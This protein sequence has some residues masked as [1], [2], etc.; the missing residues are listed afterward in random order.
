MWA[1]RSLDSFIQDV[2]HARRTMRK[3]P[4]FVGTAILMLALAI[5]G[6]TAMFAIIRG[7][8]LKPLQYHHSDK[9]VRMSGGATPTRFAEMKA[10][11]RSFAELGAY[12]SQENVTLSSIRAPEVLRSVQ[13]SASFLRILD[14]VP[15]LGRGFRPEE[16]S[17]SGAPVAMISAELWQRASVLILM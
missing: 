10:G 4:V 13:I 5:G 16:D 17:I 9:L 15:M 6:N 12:T 3:H 1:V 2:V 7:V 11:A 8:L 14:L